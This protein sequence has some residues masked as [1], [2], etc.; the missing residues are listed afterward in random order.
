MSRPHGR[1]RVSPRHPEAFAVCDRCAGWLNLV[2]LRWQYEFAGRGL[3]NTRY[4]FCQRCLDTP[5]P[6]L[7]ARIIRADPVPK[8]NARVEPFA[9]DNESG[10]E[11]NGGVLTL[12]SLQGY[13]VS[14]LGLPP[15]AVWSNALAV[16]VV[17][18]QVP[19]TDP[20]APPMYYGGEIDAA[21]LLLYGGGNLPLIDPGVKTQLWNN[22]GVV[23]ISSG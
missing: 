11:N 3:Y 14:A 13:P 7:K 10:F 9:I 21:Q 23:N 22:S 20:T 17:P 16:N 8:L 2:D 4:L 19:D 1:A 6:Q 5:Q 12:T 18:G 15:G